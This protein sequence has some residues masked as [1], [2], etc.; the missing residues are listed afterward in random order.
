M[1][2]ER[3]TSNA[4]VFAKRGDPWVTRREGEKAFG[5]NLDSENP[6]MDAMLFAKRAQPKVPYVDPPKPKKAEA[7]YT[8]RKTNII[9]R[10]RRQASSVN[11]AKP[12]DDNPFE[13]FTSR[14]IVDE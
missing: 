13:R 7:S 3:Y 2:K 12:D 11:T 14:G 8:L 1:A 10:A 5:R 9:L 4:G 6:D